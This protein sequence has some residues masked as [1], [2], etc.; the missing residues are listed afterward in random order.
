V[1]LLPRFQ[2]PAAFTLST[3]SSIP[4]LDETPNVAVL[5]VS[6]PYSPDLDL[7]DAL[8]AAVQREKRARVKTTGVTILPIRIMGRASVR[9]C[10]ELKESS[11]P[12]PRAT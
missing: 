4:F 5:P 8:R 7:G 11:M 1:D 9:K 3:K 6:D 10:F 2:C 12:G